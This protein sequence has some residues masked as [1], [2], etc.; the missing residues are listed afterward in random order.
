MIRIHIHKLNSL[1]L[2]VILAI[3]IGSASMYSFQQNSR[4]EYRQRR[5][6]EKDIADLK[7]KV[8]ILTAKNKRERPKKNADLKNITVTISVYH[9][10]TA[11]GWGDGCRTNDGTEICERNLTDP[12]LCAVSPDLLNDIPFGTTIELRTLGGFFVGEC[13]C[14]DTTDKRMKRRID[15]LVPKEIKANL[16]PDSEAIIR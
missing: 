6:I 7:V 3:I 16:F 15:V 1:I 4:Y 2:V 10:G 11:E 8:G 14:A 5:I 12:W 9:P 13:I